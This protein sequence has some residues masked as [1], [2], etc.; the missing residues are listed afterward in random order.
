M[1]RTG[2]AGVVSEVGVHRVDRE[3]PVIEQHGHNRR[4]RLPSSGARCSA[5]SALTP[6][7]VRYTFRVVHLDAARAGG[8]VNLVP[9]LDAGAI[10]ATASAQARL[11]LDGEVDAGGG[12]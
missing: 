9:H 2:T 7:V 3:V 1:L 4:R 12:F 5:P 8:G 11:S 10:S 6:P